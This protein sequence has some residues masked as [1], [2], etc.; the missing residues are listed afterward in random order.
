MMYPR[1]ARFTNP[2][3]KTAV[4]GLL[5][6]ASTGESQVA[7]VTMSDANSTAIVDVGSDAGMY[8]WSVNGPGGVNQLAKQWFWYRIGSTDINLA[9]NTISPAT[10]NQTTAGGN[11]LFIV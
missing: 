9:I 7:P 3:L 8:F 1:R 5:L 2:L 10:Y 4:L 6:L 11:D